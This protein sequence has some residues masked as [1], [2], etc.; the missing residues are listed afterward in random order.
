MTQPPQAPLPHYGPAP[1]PYPPYP[2]RPPRQPTTLWRPLVWTLC[3]SAVGAVL[4]IVAVIALVVAVIVLFLMLVAAVV[5]S[6][7]LADIFSDGWLGGLG[8]V[9]AELGLEFAVVVGIALAIGTASLLLLRLSTSV[10]TWPPFLQ[11]LAA[12]GVTYLVGSA[13]IAIALELI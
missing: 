9:L 1:V 10:R 3:L 4:M 11:G 5:D 12:S 7:T 13:T 2:P 8:G 6:F